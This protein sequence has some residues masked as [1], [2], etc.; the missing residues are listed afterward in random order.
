MNSLVYLLLVTFSFDFLTFT[1]PMVSEFQKSPY[2]AIAVPVVSAYDTGRIPSIEDLRAQ[3]TQFTTLTT[4]HIWPWIFLNRMVGTN[5]AEKNAHAQVPY[6]LGIKGADLDNSTGAQNDFFQVWRVGLQ[7][8]KALGSPGVVFDPEFY[9]DYAAYKIP[10]LARQTG[11]TPDEV[12]QLLRG[13][14]AH[15]ADIAQEELPG[16]K[17]L[18][19][20]TGLGRPGWYTE[21]PASYYLSSAYVAMGL[22]ERIKQSGYRLTVISGGEVGLGYCHSSLEQM[23]MKIDNR[24]KASLPFLDDYAGILVLGGTTTLWL[25]EA[26]KTGY[27]TQGYCGKCPAHNVEELQPYLEKLFRNYGYAWIWASGGGGYLAFDPQVTPRFN[28]TLARA[29]D[30]T[31]RASKK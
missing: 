15:M 11:K 4:K 24:F 19:F 22:L 14:G 31:G 5:L 25:D 21:G 28:T 16:A 8:A 13:V 20:F 23:Q 3:I 9:N 26:H 17:I 7:A 6:F 18:I 2:H 29:L 1:P 12:M 30:A 27:F 10:E